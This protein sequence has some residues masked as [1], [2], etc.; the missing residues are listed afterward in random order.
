[1]AIMKAE[2][3]KFLSL[4]S[5]AVLCFHYDYYLLYDESLASLGVLLEKL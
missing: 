1:M 2:L 5:Y 3:S 4:V